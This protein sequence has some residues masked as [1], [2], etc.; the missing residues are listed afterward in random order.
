MSGYSVKIHFNQLLLKG[1][2]I[3]KVG[4]YLSCYPDDNATLLNGV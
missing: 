4:H 2:E 1:Y 3:V